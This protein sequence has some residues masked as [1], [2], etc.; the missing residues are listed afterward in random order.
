MKVLV[1]VFNN[2]YTDQRVEKICKTLH[3]QNYKVELLGNSW[4]GL[5]PIERPYPYFRILLKSQNL[6]LGYPEF[7]W[8]LYNELLKRVDNKTILYAN[9]LDTLLPN[10]LV[11][12]KKNI[13]LIFDSHEI[14]TEMP[15]LKGRFTQKIWRIL[16]KSIL[17]K[18][19]YFI[20]ASESYSLWF[21]EKYGVEKPIVVQNFPERVE[22][23]DFI[24]EESSK[25]II[26]YQGTINPFR[27][28]DKLIPALKKIDNAELWIFGNG[29]KLDEYKQLTKKLVL[30]KKV[31][32]FGAISP[33]K[34]KEFTTKADVG[35]SIE[36]NNGLSYYYSLPNKISDYIQAR[37]PVLTSDFPEM[38]KIVENFNVGEKIQ[39]HSEEELVLKISNILRKGKNFYRDKLNIAANELCWENEAPKIL[40]LFEKVVKENFH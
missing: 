36:E 29:P 14:F 8:K 39:N 17:P 6:K 25:K 40:Q 26:I 21:A 2:L 16:E 35:I 32:F 3:D 23:L 27:G 4:G 30:D 19:K 31:K 13:P 5:K 37:I 38:K 15:S 11:S 20:T 10:Y 18:I 24:A 12:K 22:N 9:D 34:L 28:L 33:Q 1:S 7:N